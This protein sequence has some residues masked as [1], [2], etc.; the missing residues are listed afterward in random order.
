MEVQMSNPLHAHDCTCCTFLGSSD[1]VQATDGRSCTGV[2]LYAHRNLP[3]RGVTLIRRCSSEGSDYMARTQTVEDWQAYLQYND[4]VRSTYGLAFDRAVELGVF[5]ETLDHIGTAY[6]NIL[7]GDEAGPDDYG[8]VNI[9][10]LVD[11]PD[12]YLL[13]QV[14]TSGRSSW[15]CINSSDLLSWEA[16]LEKATRLI[17]EFDFAVSVDGAALSK[18]LAD[19]TLGEDPDDFEAMPEYQEANAAYQTALEAFIAS[20][21]PSRSAQDLIEQIRQFH[22]PASRPGL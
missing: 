2:D 8:A 22:A 13:D 10:R 9:Y 7:E 20:Y 3:S 14:G 16:V 19:I 11:D 15:T 12:V 1:A 5:R 6:S 21:T 18:G 4:F 17:A